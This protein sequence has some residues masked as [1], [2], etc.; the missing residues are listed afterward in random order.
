MGLLR[1][2]SFSSLLPPPFF[3]SHERGI[4]KDIPPGKGGSDEV[5]GS[6]VGWG[7]LCP[8]QPEAGGVPAGLGAAGGRSGG[9]SSSRGERGP[10]LGTQLNSPLLQPTPGQSQIC[11]L[12]EE[13]T[14]EE[15]TDVSCFGEMLV[16]KCLF[17]RASEAA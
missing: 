14:S 16:S 2:L 10:T 8:G 1:W 6:S 11:G 15:M 7:L 17:L 12:L 9:G 13:E 5:P 3:S 4:S